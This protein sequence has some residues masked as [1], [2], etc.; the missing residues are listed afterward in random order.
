MFY[1]DMFTCAYNK[2]IETKTNNNKEMKNMHRLSDACIFPHPTPLKWAPTMDISLHFRTSRV[3]SRQRDVSL[4][5]RQ[6]LC[7]ITGSVS[8]T[9]WGHFKVRLYHG[10]KKEGVL[11]LV[12][13]GKLDVVLTTYDTMKLNLVRL[14]YL[15]LICCHFLDVRMLST[16]PLP[17]IP[18]HYLFHIHMLWL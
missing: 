7:C 6:A 17:R 2:I 14:G 1:T 16:P 9:L 5:S 12:A 18:L 4:W 10:T 11:E 15:W 13:K 8:W 3:F